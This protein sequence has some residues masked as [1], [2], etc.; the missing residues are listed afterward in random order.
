M[1]GAATARVAAG[2]ESSAAARAGAGAGWA[3]PCC[4]LFAVRAPGTPGLRETLRAQR[5]GTKRRG[6]TRAERRARKKGQATPTHTSPDESLP[7]CA[8]T[9]GTS[10]GKT[11]ASSSSRLMVARDNWSKFLCVH[12]Q[13]TPCSSHNVTFTGRKV[14][15]FQEEQSLKAKIVQLAQNG[16]GVGNC[17]GDFANALRGGAIG[18]IHSECVTA[19]PRFEPASLCPKCSNG[20]I[21]FCGEK[22]LAREEQIAVIFARDHVKQPPGKAAVLDHIT[23]DRPQTTRH[24]KGHISAG[25]VYDWNRRSLAANEG[26][27][28][29]GRILCGCVACVCVSAPTCSS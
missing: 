10:F 13:I 11:C 25:A 16:K 23:R 8:A 9:R 21:V 19:I 3:C 15:T 14:T 28:L 5:H 7:Y 1:R 12:A 18:S 26:T 2:D 29:E 6:G 20:V 22:T 27:S 17:N 24:G 4:V